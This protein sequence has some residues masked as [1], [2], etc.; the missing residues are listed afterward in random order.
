MYDIIIIIVIIMYKN[1]F[2]TFKFFINTFI[3][4]NLN[5]IFYFL[6]KFKGMMDFL[7]I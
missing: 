7:F 4:L 5:N 3:F 2:I 1:I 6:K